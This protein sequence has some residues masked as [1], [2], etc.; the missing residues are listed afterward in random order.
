MRRREFIGLVSGAV[1][2]PLA[3]RAQPPGRIR[4]IGVPDP[5][6][7]RAQ[8]TGPRSSRE[9]RPLTELFIHTQAYL[10]WRTAHV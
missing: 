3:A 8:G 4:R 10:Q 6:G 9:A 7:A 1:A 5:S 2:W